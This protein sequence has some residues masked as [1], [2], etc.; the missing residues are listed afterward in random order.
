MFVQEG[1][2]Q[3]WIHFPNLLPLLPEPRLLYLRWLYQP[4]TWDNGNSIQVACFLCGWVLQGS[5]LKRMTKVTRGSHQSYSPQIKLK[6]VS[7]ELPALKK[8]IIWNEHSLLNMAVFQIPKSVGILVTEARIPTSHSTYNTYQMAAIWF[9]LTQYGF[10]DAPFPCPGYPPPNIPQFIG[11]P[12]SQPPSCSVWSRIVYYFTSS[13][14]CDPINAAWYSN[15]MMGLPT[16][17]SF[18]VPYAI[19]ILWQM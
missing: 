16:N 6:S 12:N 10:P 15:H 18:F 5:R 9:Y 14:C 3:Q 1:P 19:N 17:Q 8:I 11:P 13:G 4:I 7:Q 2:N